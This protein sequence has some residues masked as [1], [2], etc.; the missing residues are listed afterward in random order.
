MSE[1]ES[2]KSNSG[3]HVHHSSLS[4]LDGEYQ[5]LLQEYVEEHR[6]RL[7]LIAEAPI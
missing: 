3:D 2:R 7:S 1:G 4:Q 5:N 6:R